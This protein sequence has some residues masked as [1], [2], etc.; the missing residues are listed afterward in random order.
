MRCLIWLAI[1]AATILM[2]G[3]LQAETTIQFDSASGLFRV[4]HQSA[5]IVRAAFVFWHGNWQWGGL[6]LNS[7]RKN[8]DGAYSFNGKNEQ[9]GM[10]LAGHARGATPN[11]LVWTIDAQEGERG[12]KNIYGGISFLISTQALVDGN[13]APAA[14]I[15]PNKSGWELQLQP[16]QPPLKVEFDPPLEELHF[17]QGNNNEIRAYFFVANKRTDTKQIRVTVSLPP[18]ARIVP[19]LAERVAEPS[20]N[21]W[22]R[23]LIGWDQTPV[24]LSFLNTPERPAGKRGFLRAEGEALAFED[25]TKAKFWGTNITAYALFQTPKAAVQ[26]QARRLSRLGFNLVRI[27]HH[28]SGWVEPNIF[29]TPATNT[30]SLNPNSLEHLD[31]WIK[32]LRD[33][34]VYIW[35][36]LHVGREFTTQDGIEYFDEISKGKERERVPGFSYVNK[37]IRDKLKAFN[38]AYLSHINPYTS[39]AYKDDPAV[40]SI[41]IT[42]ENDLTQHFGNSLLPDANVPNHNKFFMSEARKFASDHSLDFEKTWRSWEHGP[43]KLFLNDLEHRFNTEMIAHLRALGVKSPIVTTNY[44]GNMSLAGLPSLTDGGIIDAHSYGGPDGFTTNPRYRANMASWIAAANVAGKPLSVSEWNVEPF[45]VF[46]RFNIPTYIAALA[47]LQDWDALMQ[48]AYAQVPLNGPHGA[49]NWH[50]FNDPALLA[51]LPA[52]ALLYRQGHVAEANQTYYLDF[53]SELIGREISP[54]SSRAIRTMTETSKLRVGLPAMPELP[55]VK[56][57]SAPPGAIIV[58]DINQD[59]TAKNETVVCSDTKELC[60]DWK[61]GVFTVNTP[62]SQIA[63][64]W[65][66]GHAVELDNMSA[67]IATANASVA[68]QSLDGAPIRE[69][70]KILISMAAQSVPFRGDE[71]PFLSE[72]IEG[73]LRV[74]ARQGLKLYAIAATGARKPLDFDVVDGSYSIR[75]NAELGTYWL[76]LE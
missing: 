41:L 44:W 65:I 37:D 57:S 17:E 60:R 71:L 63:S 2:T 8:S 7:R 20:P 51:M 53:G 29:A 27:H 35:L 1:S 38:A 72:P 19:T 42:N 3:R 23:N 50:A 54:D 76:M 46:D 64:G 13:F 58:K 47:R 24:D 16:E 22:Y 6:D 48:Y 70:G 10:V 62:R 67:Q 75:L 49:S 68:V 32:C 31:W 33:E 12:L 21:S 25:G 59:V 4:Q 18:Q 69:A 15:L 43:S 34:G 56:P 73:T 28:D 5:D 11:S 9:T 39:L 74:R 14:T 30:L 26:E 55:W 66:G 61:R 40:A 36:D 45:P 52:A